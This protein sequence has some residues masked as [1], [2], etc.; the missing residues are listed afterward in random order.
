MPNKAN[1][2]KSSAKTSTQLIAHFSAKGCGKGSFGERFLKLRIKDGNRRRLVRL[3][4]DNFHGEAMTNQIDA[5]N[6]KGANLITKKT[7]A[8]FADLIEKSASSEVSFRVA[9]RPGLHGNCFVLEDGVITVK[10]RRVEKHLEAYPPDLMAKF[11]CGGSLK[12]WKKIQRYA[13]GN[14]R[15][16]LGLGIAFSGVV[17]AITGNETTGIQYSGPGAPEK[18]HLLPLSRRFG[19][20]TWGRWL[21]NTEPRRPGCT[22]STPWTRS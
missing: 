1:D 9:T 16:I 2:A 19:G 21:R 7:R 20:V 5:L 8:A 4:I 13:S 12:G 15:F 18:R 3:R 14:S 17:A 22:P 10:G 11:R 6:R